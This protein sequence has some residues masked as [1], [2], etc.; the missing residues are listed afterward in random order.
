MVLFIGAAVM[1]LWTGGSSFLLLLAVSSCKAGQERINNVGR[2]PKEID[3]I[4]A[5]STREYSLPFLKRG[6]G[7]FKF[8]GE[9]FKE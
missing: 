2:R 9:G 1:P 8:I 4:S 6:V 7:Q 3:H 5:K